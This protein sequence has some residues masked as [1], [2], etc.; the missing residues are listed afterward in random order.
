VANVN[1]SRL[2]EFSAFKTKPKKKSKSRETLE[3]RP[4]QAGLEPGRSPEALLRLAGSISK[5]D[6]RKMKAAI[7]EG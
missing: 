4:A 1:C 7:E 6:L 3:K 5:S 2:W